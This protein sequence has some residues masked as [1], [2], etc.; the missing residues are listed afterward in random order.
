MLSGFLK[1]GEADLIRKAQKKDAASVRALYDA[2]VQYLTAICRRYVSSTEEVK[3]ILQEAFIKIFSSLKSFRYNG[4]GSLRSWMSRIVIN[5]TLM[6]L[7]KN[8]K[9]EFVFR[10]DTFPDIE[11]EDPEPEGIPPEILSDFIL[12]LPTGYRTIFNLYVFE[13]K[14]HKEIA[15]QL[16]IKENTSTS[17]YHRAKAMLAK[18]IKDYRNEQGLEK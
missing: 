3:D 2:H 10:T 18:M 12:R 1:D 7:R 16:G 17:Q 4:P 6:Y 15:E 14:S 11:T 13:Q 9:E 5:E 8:K